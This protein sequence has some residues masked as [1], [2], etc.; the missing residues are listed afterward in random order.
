MTT[1]CAQG[2]S[3][4]AV[5]PVGPVAMTRELASILS[6]QPLSEE[7]AWK[8]RRDRLSAIEDFPETYHRGRRAVHPSTV[9]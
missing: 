2:I 6:T 7:E 1:R 3:I 4:G 9:G 8:S 5:R